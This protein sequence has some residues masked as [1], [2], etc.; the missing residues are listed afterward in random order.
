MNKVLGYETIIRPLSAEEG[1]GYLAEFPDLPGCYA[2]GETPEEALKEAEDALV[3]W[4][5][6]AQELDK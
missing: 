6:T 4:I 1:G 2:D 3:S 5:K